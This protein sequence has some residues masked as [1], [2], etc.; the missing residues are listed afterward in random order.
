MKKR[1]KKP[2]MTLQIFEA[3]EYI[4]A[5]WAIA[6]D[7]GIAG[8]NGDC[9]DP[10]HTDNSNITHAKKDAGTGCGWS[11]NQYIFKNKDGSFS[12]TEINTD[13]LGNLNTQ[14]T[15]NENYYNLSSKIND[16]DPGD[17]IY[18][19]TSAGEGWNQRTWY[20]KGTV[21]ATYPGHPNRS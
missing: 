15:F 21:E 20:H 5:C 10:I 19:T 3:N 17:V 12:V 2:N 8:G 9:P 4:A 16:V 11:T 14:L 1:W 6:C 13:Q 7:Y 18:W